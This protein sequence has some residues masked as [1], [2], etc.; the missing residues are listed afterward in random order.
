MRQAKLAAFP[1]T[2]MEYIEMAI[3]VGCFGCRAFLLPPLACRL[4]HLSYLACLG[5]PCPKSV[6]KSMP[7]MT[8]R[9]RE[10]VGFNAPHAC[11]RACSS[12]P[13]LCCV[14]NPTRATC[15]AAQFGYVAIFAV[16]FPIGSIVCWINN[17]LEKRADAVKIAVLMQ[18]PRYL[19]TEDIGSM[20]SILE[21]IALISVFVNCGILCLSSEAYYAYFPERFGDRPSWQVF[22]FT[23]V[24]EHLILMMKSIVAALVPDTP[25]WVEVEKTKVEMRKEAYRLAHLSAEQ[26]ARREQMQKRRQET[27]WKQSNDADI[28]DGD[29]F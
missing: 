25:L 29:L 17:L 27:D 21:F 15:F 5:G 11:M 6:C 4:P 19:G 2:H 28:E 3:Q 20:Q 13:H 12:S 1:G 24:V 16:A 14:H 26:V 8:L 10:E 22:A 9:M 7:S 23:V 18:R